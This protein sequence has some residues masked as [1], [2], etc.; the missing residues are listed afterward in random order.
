MN[1][2]EYE[3]AIIGA[4]FAGIGSGI[5]L[6]QNNYNSFIIFERKTE[7]GGT[8]RDNTYPG[9]AC[10]IPSMLYSFSFEPNP[11]WSRAFSP[12]N[13]ILA[14]LKNCIKKY[15]LNE[16]IRYNTEIQKTEFL[17]SEGKWELTTNDGLVIRAKMVISATGPLNQPFLPQIKGRDSFEGKSFHSLYW[18]HSYDLKDK[19]VAVIGTGASAI[20]FVPQIAPLV[21]KLK[22]FQRTAPWISPKGDKAYDEKS[23]ARFKNI[24]FYQ[25]FWREVIYYFLEHRGKSQYT[26][27]PIREK[28]KQEAL[29]HLHASISD[30]TLRKKFTPNY[31][32]GCKRVLISDNYYPT[33]NRDNVDLITDVA[34]E[35]HPNG[36]TDKTGHFHEVDAIIYG[37]GFVTTEYSHLYDIKGLEGRNLF[38]EWDNK[39]GEAYY[40]MTATG[41]PNFVFMV[42]PNSG[43][44]HNSIIH[45][46]ESQINYILDYLKKLK[47]LPNHGYLD[48]KPDVMRSFNDKIQ[49]ELKEMVWSSGGCNSYYLKGMNGKNTSIWPGST[50]K[51]R[52]ETKKINIQ[53]YNIVSDNNLKKADILA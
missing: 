53:D 44:G 30:E 25:K 31:E 28:R 6:S 34:I 48:L 4:G 10:D 14:Y 46:M 41:F 21:K 32:L 24:P 12:H 45:M 40:G 42:G 33:F 27:N 13:E 23:Q 38:K 26:N 16:K 1:V 47:K 22:V 17:K 51:Y 20:Q 49:E 43:L 19:K 37:T 5:K 3:V 35:I 36:I 52:K 9:C 39:G 18:D 11:S 2:D 8:W 15:N 50:M 29:A 7:V